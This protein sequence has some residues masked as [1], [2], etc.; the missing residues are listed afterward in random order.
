MPL[1]PMPNPRTIEQLIEAVDDFNTEHPVGTA[2]TR[3]KLINP[4]REPE[5]TVTRS[6]AWVMGGHSAVVLVAGVSGAVLLESVVPK[7]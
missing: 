2:V 4:L 6:Q 7:K 3:Y 5:E 1:T